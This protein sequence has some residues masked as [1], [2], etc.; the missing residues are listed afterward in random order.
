MRLRP[1]SF[2]PGKLFHPAPGIPQ[3]VLPPSPL[4]RNM[5]PTVPQPNAPSMKQAPL[6]PMRAP[7]GA[8]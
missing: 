3:K 6:Q 5:K 1:Y 8:C 4:H 2:L 7:Q